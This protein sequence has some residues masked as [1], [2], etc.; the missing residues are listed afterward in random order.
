MY[1]NN[2]IIANYGC[3]YF[4]K[5]ACSKIN[6]YGTPRN[7]TWGH[8]PTMWN[9]GINTFHGLNNDLTKTVAFR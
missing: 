1:N 4:N 9:Y 3:I 7:R 5:H 2:I 8:E 6:L